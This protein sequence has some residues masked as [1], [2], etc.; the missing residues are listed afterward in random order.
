LKFFG[1]F[2]YC[3]LVLGHAV[4]I[5]INESTLPESNFADRETSKHYA[6]APPE[7]G[8]LN[9]FKIDLTFCGS[10]LSNNYE[11]ALGNSDREGELPAE[12]IDFILGI[13]C[14]TW[15]LRER[16]L[17]RTYICT[18]D[19]VKTGTKNLQ[20]SIRYDASGVPQTISFMDNGTPFQFPGLDISASSTVSWLRPVWKDMKL[21]R[22]G[23]VEDPQDGIRVSLTADGSKI[24]IR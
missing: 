11:I 23:Y 18:N 24:I 15:F 17:R 16:G 10:T 4:G 5:T 19:F 3:L 14:G 20:L 13:S 2:L 9:F 22:R 12:D 8:K 6:F 1:W 7:L 21:T